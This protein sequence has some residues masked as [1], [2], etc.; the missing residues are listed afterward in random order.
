MNYNVFIEN[1]YQDWDVDI[2]SVETSVQKIFDY[3]LYDL[4]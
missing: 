1:E 4:S 3:R 2:E